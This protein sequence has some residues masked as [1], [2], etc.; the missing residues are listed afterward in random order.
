M[1]LGLVC[2]TL[3]QTLNEEGFEEQNREESGEEREDPG[4]I[5]VLLGRNVLEGLSRKPQHTMYGLT[6]LCDI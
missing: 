4:P 6:G 5:P 2:R 3:A 1:S